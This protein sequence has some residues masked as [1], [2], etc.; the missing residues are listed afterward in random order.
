MRCVV[1]IAYLWCEVLGRAAECS[2]RLSPTDVL[3]AETEVGNLDV[4]VRVEQKILQL[5]IPVTKEIYVTT[6]QKGLQNNCFPMLS[7]L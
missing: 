4:A 1:S 5:E 7:R 3:L 6:R 2:G